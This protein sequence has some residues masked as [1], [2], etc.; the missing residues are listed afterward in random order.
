MDNT[1]LRERFNV[2]KNKYF[3]ISR[4]IINAVEKELIKK[5]PRKNYIPF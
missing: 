5:G 1:S 3:K 4:L 2:P